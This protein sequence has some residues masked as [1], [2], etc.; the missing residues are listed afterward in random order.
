MKEKIDL[1]KAY[2]KVSDFTKSTAS[3]V[4]EKS[5]VILEKSKDSVQKSA[6]TV[7]DTTVEAYKKAVTVLD[8]NGN[9][10]V[11]IEDIILKAMKV[12]GI[13]I[14]REKF[15]TREFGKS[16]DSETLKLIIQRNPLSAGIPADAIN[17][18]ADDTIKYERNCVS[19]ISAALGMPGGA[20][21]IATIPADI[22]K[23]VAKWFNVHMTK[24]VFAGFFKKTIPVV[25]GVVGAGITFATF[26]PCCE[27][28]K[29]SLE[30]TALSNPNINDK[31][32]IIIDFTDDNDN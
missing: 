32:E 7:K 25:G 5:D 17:T 22:V 3:V 20:A 23:S 6:V 4:K 13:R 1:K 15:L 28:L 10:E 12:P 27:K 30:E 21:M 18:L 26:G 11:D 19:G 24:E 31:E 16:C 29:K 9:G 14:N 2:S 8:E